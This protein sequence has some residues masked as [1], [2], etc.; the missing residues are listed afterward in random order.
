MMK[1][2][3][4]MTC[5]CGT[6]WR[7]GIVVLAGTL[8]AATVS[9]CSGTPAPSTTSAVSA[10]S[11][12]ATLR[13]ADPCSFLD[14]SVVTAN[15]LVHEPTGTE[16][17]SRNC[18][19]TSDAFAVGILVRWDREMLVDFSENYPSLV[20]TDVDLGGKKVIMAKRTD[21][22]TCGAQVLVPEPA[23][24]EISVTYRPPDT[25]DT[26]CERLKTIGGTV[27]QMLRDQRLLDEQSSSPITS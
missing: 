1:E 4:F 25:A 13:D 3:V 5:G 12:P 19:W 16:P 8:V 23:A 24:V 7:V 27:V 18:F 26:A 2:R 14:Q 21:R 11:A 6:I 22:P 15:G 17:N 9:S 10:S 20:G